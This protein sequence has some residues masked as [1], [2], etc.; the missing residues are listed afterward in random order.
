MVR[1]LVL[2]GSGCSGR[3]RAEE[4]QR[5]GQ[6]VDAIFATG[7]ID[8]AAEREIRFWIDAGR[9]PALVDAAARKRLA[10]IHRQTWERARELEAI[11]FQ[12]LEPPA[13]GRLDEI[14]VPALIVVGE[15]EV[16]A[17]RETANYL[18]SGITGARLEVV[19]GASHL[20]A[21]ENP[22]AFNG[23]LLDFLSSLA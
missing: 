16:P 2:S 17:L 20:P 15:F 21:I 7:D 22:A 5:H 10:T 18:V 23:V 11:D 13:A 14:A 19:A 6:E 12:L 4:V 3:P 1:A 8:E 9:D